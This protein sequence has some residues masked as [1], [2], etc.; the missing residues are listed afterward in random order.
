M[1]ELQDKPRWNDIFVKRPVIAIVVSLL[2][3]LAGIRSAVDIPVLQFPVIQSSSIQIIT[4]Y[5]GRPPSR[6]KA[7]V[8]EPIE[9]VANAIPGVDYV[10]S[11]TTSGESIVT[12][13]M[14]LN[15]DS[16]DALA[17]LSSGLSQIRLE[18][19]DGAED[20]FIEVSRADSPLRAFISRSVSPKHAPSER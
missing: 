12:A 7:F 8:T 19:P 11:V 10:E 3:L 1:A 9:R 14:Q 5:P 2:L 17:E 4:P 15:E 20:P 16:T 6:S 13:W 18:L